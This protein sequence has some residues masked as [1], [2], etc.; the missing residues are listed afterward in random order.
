MGH[1]H[2]LEEENEG[3]VSANKDTLGNRLAAPEGS[4]CRSKHKPAA[5]AAVARDSSLLLHFSLLDNN[6]QPVEK[7]CRVHDSS[8]QNGI[9]IILVNLTIITSCHL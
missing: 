4:N 9:M 2:G 3:G 8:S 5:A 7:E 6:T 1:L